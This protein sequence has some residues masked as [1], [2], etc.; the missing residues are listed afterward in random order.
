MARYN[1]T[2]RTSGSDLGTYEA[3]TAY[4]AIEVMHKDAGYAS[5]DA[6]AEALGQ[7]AEDLIAD[8]HAVV[9]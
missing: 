4:D 8:V 9:V 3:P 6:A 2:S 1:L 5:I 7:T